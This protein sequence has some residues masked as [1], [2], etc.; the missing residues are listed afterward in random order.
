MKKSVQTNSAF[1]DLPKNKCAILT[2]GK[3][4]SVICELTGS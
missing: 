2:N 1:C 3:F 4:S